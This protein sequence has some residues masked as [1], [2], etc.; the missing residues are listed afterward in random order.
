MPG[1]ANKTVNVIVVPK[2]DFE[3]TGKEAL[4]KA[5]EWAKKNIVG[6]HTAKDS[7]DN[8]F[9]YNISNRAVRK[10]VSTSSYGKSDNIGLHLSVLKMLPDVI[11][12][13]IEAE[14]HPDY[15]KG[16]DDKRSIENGINDSALIHRFYVAV[17]IDG[18]WYRVK[19]TIKEYQDPHAHNKPHDYE[20]TKIELIDDLPNSS[21]PLNSDISHSLAATKLLENVEK[22]Y[23]K[24]KKLLDESKKTQEKGENLY[25]EAENEDSKKIFEQAKK[26]F[27]TTR[28]IMEAGYVLP[29]G[30]MLDFSGRHLMNPGSDTSFLRGRRTSD[31]REISSIAYEKDGNTKTGV[32][33]DMPDFIRRGAIRIDDNAG[34]INLSGKPTASQ[35]EALRQQYYKN[36]QKCLVVSI[37]CFIFA[38]VKESFEIDDNY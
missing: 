22:S 18:E 10:F 9:D 37:E 29:D 5:E 24:G 30:S 19:T 20:V 17:N 6:T 15:N 4:Q 38:T 12:N 28:D 35:K 25:N 8:P 32:E 33:T 21:W 36:A 26:L 14:V 13:S 16:A 7:N 34:N 1:L 27:G 3:G 23:D 2:H 31:H 11:S